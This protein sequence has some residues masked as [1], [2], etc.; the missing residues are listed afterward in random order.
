MTFCVQNIS[1][2]FC[3]VY[4]Y[5]MYLEKQELSQEEGSYQLP[6]EQRIYII[7]PLS[8]P[9]Q[10][11]DPECKNFRFVVKLSCLQVFNN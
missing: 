6:R 2:F 1:I 3:Q 7:N 8:A 4:F 10:S 9:V 11:F 5:K